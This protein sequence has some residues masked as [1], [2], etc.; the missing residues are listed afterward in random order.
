M[1][2]HYSCNTVAGIS[3]QIGTVGSYRVCATGP[4]IDPILVTLLVRCEIFFSRSPDKGY[5]WLADDA[6]SGMVFGTSTSAQPSHHLEGQIRTITLWQ[7]C[8][9][10]AFLCPSDTSFSHTKR[11]IQKQFQSKDLRRLARDWETVHMLMVK[12][13]H[14]SVHRMGWT[15]TVIIVTR[16]PIL[17]CSHSKNIWLL[18]WLK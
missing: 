15:R 6:F 2:D 9:P 17:T 18:F 12:Q 16:H 3:N 5:S 4:Y 13:V 11:K 10:G 14:Q 8:A 1:I 7:L